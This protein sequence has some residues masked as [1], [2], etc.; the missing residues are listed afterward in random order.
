MS[1]CFSY[2]KADN[3]LQVPKGVDFD[4]Y[5][6]I[7]LIYIIPTSDRHV[8]EHLSQYSYDDPVSYYRWLGLFIDYSS[9]D[10]RSN[11]TTKTIKR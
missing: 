2:E 6:P 10:L 11:G 3:A 4:F 5:Y 8:P 1:R 7:P 9:I